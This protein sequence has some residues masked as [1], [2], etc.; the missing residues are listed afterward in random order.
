MLN[1]HRHSLNLS[2]VYLLY[3]LIFA[4]SKLFSFIIICAYQLHIRISW[5]LHISVDDKLINDSERL[6]QQLTTD[7]ADVPPSPSPQLML[8]TVRSNSVP[9]LLMQPVYRLQP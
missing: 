2:M 8:M 5:L 1:K 7:S 3:L 4:R 9:L 6:V